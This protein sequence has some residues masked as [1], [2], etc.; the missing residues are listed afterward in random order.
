MRRTSRGGAAVT[1]PRRIPAVTVG[2]MQPPGKRADM[3]IHDEQPLNAESPAG[4]LAE[5]D[6]TALDAFYV[7]NHGEI[8]E[9]DPAAWRLRV[10]GLVENELELSLDELRGRF[11][12]RGLVATLQCAGNRRAGLIA[13]RDIP[14]EAPWGPGAIGTAAWRGVALAD[15][16]AAAGLKPQAGHIA[17]LGADTAKEAKP[18]QRFGGS[19]PARKA[20]TGEVLL[21]WEMNGEPLAPA[22]G[23]PLRVLVPGYIGA[24]SVKWLVRVTAQ[25]EPSENYFQ[26]S[27]YRLLPPEA[28]P[29]TVPP[30]TGIPLG[31]VA[32]NADILSPPDGSTVPAGPIDL[33]GYAF[34][35]D[36]RG[37]GRVDVSIDGAASWQQA[38][39]LA[40]PSPWS[41]RRWRASVVLPEGPATVLARAWDSSGSTQPED[42]AHV[43]NPKGYVNSAWASISLTVKR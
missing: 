31:P 18:P 9:L 3:I 12:E 34:A 7:R 38:E 20:L 16:L 4:A 43:W 24:R 15:V 19:I 27:T 36:D 30:G 41:W 17:F 13:V 1:I 21:A 10:D 35:G 2:R 22:H 25:S 11:E 37:V 29:S 33:C 40:E 26:A 14:G 32:L 23:A 42:P 39:L 28:D 6:L 5:G 8:P